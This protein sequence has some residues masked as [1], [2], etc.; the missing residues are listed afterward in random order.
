MMI[1]RLALIAVAVMLAIAPTLAQDKPVD[2]EDVVLGAAGTPAQFVFDR[3]G[4]G[5]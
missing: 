2:T 5:Y 4:S 1:R 3:L